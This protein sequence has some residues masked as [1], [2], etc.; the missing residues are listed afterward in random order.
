VLF[1]CAEVPNFKVIVGSSHRPSFEEGAFEESLST[2]FRLWLE[3]DPRASMLSFCKKML[4]FP[5]QIIEKTLRR[6]SDLDML[7]LIQDPETVLKDD[8]S[9]LNRIFEV[10]LCFLKEIQTA[11][12][13][14]KEWNEGIVIE[15][16]HFRDSTRSDVDFSE[17]GK[18]FSTQTLFFLEIIGLPP[19][20][21]TA[22][23]LKQ[24]CKK[25]LKCNPKFQYRFFDLLQTLL[26]N[27]ARRLWKSEKLRAYPTRGTLNSFEALVNSVSH[28]T[29]FIIGSPG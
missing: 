23:K 15:N 2:F 6:I 12:C 17:A 28:E 25:F 19:S 27:T 9:M 18:Y 21:R 8:V 16:L 14:W 22:S 20:P 13:W 11:Y 3:E 29:H 24:S 26:V 10:E 7:S 5:A 4:G 1:E